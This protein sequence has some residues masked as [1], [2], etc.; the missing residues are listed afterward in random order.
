MKKIFVLLMTFVFILNMLHAKEEDGDDE[1]EKRI[2]AY[3]YFGDDRHRHRFRDRLHPMG[4]G[5][6]RGA[7]VGS[8]S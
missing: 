3:R 1:N 6:L 2:E 8:A 7:A 4:N 5:L